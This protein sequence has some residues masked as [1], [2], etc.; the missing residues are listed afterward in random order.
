MRLGWTA[1]RATR[2]ATSSASLLARASIWR[3]NTKPSAAARSTSIATLNTPKRV[4]RDTRES[5]SDIATM[6]GR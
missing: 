5:V 3:L 6:V 4:S 2:T 1:A